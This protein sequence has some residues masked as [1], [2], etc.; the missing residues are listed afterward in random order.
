LSS[1]GSRQRFSERN[2]KVIIFSIFAL[3]IVKIL[4]FVNKK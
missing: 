1:G 3:K 4:A 2:D